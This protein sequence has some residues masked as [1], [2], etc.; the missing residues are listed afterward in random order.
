MVFLFF[1]FRFDCVPARTQPEV[2]H[3]DSPLLGSRPGAWWSSTSWLLTVKAA[4]EGETMA[5]VSLS[6]TIGRRYDEEE[7]EYYNG[8]HR[9]IQQRPGRQK[10][11]TFRR[12]RMLASVDQSGHSD[13]QSDSHKDDDSGAEGQAAFQTSPTLPPSSIP[14]GNNN[15]KI[16][17][18]K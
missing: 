14:T 15:K 5:R 7:T 3:T 11:H 2:S 13:G 6:K 4:A 9:S 18:H 17:G 12:V 16:A 1:I 8:L 10:T